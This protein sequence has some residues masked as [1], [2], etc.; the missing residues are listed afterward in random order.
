MFLWTLA[1]IKWQ[2]CGVYNVLRAQVTE[3]TTLYTHTQHTHTTHTHN[4]HIA[5]DSA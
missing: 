1:K 3:L 5:Q 4:T 2:K